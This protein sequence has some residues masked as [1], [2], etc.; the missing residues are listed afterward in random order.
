MTEHEADAA[1]LRAVATRMERRGEDG[2][3]EATR[4]LAQLV[5]DCIEPEVELVR[6][7]FHQAKTEIN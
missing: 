6:A 7:A 1:T 5:E 3:A 2:F 4:Q